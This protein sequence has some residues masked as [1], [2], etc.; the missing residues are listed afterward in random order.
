M[1][2]FDVGL[3]V[4]FS[5]FAT[6]TFFF[7]VYGLCYLIVVW[8]LFLVRKLKDKFKEGKDE[9]GIAGDKDKPYRR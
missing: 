6:C 7:A 5:I 3:M 1:S 8:T 2:W 9:K 4:G